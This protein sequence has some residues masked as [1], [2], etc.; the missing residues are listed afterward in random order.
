M[1]VCSL[2]KKRG[3]V[4]I[5]G[6]EEGIYLYYVVE[7]AWPLAVVWARFLPLGCLDYWLHGG[8]E[9]LGSG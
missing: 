1:M 5:R 8:W 7:G 3:E 2:E 6:A 4:W 9:G